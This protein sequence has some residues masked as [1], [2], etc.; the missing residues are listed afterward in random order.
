[1]NQ[2]ENTQGVISQ[3]LT[4]EAETLLLKHCRARYV[5]AMFETKM[6]LTEFNASLALHKQYR[7][8]VD[9]FWVTNMMRAAVMPDDSVCMQTVRN[10]AV[11]HSEMMTIHTA[12]S[13]DSTMDLRNAMEDH[14]CIW[15]YQEGSVDE[16]EITGYGLAKFLGI[17]LHKFMADQRAAIQQAA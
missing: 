7:P 6:A 9:S 2:S 1:M 16:A 8:P 17:D 12:V 14:G 11:N 3:N 15:N 10:H 5:E 4:E 13:I